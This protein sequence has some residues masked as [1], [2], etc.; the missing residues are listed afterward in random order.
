MGASTGRGG[1]IRAQQQLRDALEFPRAI[2]LATPQVLV[3]E[4][5]LHFDEQGELVDEEIRE[6][7]AELVAALTQAPALVAA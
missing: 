6:R 5:Y 3:P 7:I 1:T 2:V 4:A